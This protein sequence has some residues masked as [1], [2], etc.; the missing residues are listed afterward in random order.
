MEVCRRDT[1]VGRSQKELGMRALF[2]LTVGFLFVMA[3]TLGASA[4]TPFKIRAGWVSAPNIILP[5]IFEKKDIL[6]HYGRSYVFEAVRFT[7]AALEA[8]ALSSG[9]LEIASLGYP[10]LSTA[11]LNA[12]MEDLRV[13]ADGIQDGVN[14]YYSTEY[15]V[16]KDGPIK[17]VADL[18][19]KIVS[20]F[21]SGSA[22]DMPMRSMLRKNKLEENKDYTN[23]SVGFAN[24][25]PMLDGR[26]IDLASTTAPW[27]LDPK[28]RAKSRTLFTSLE[29]VGPTELIVLI[30]RSGTIEKNRAAFVDFFED[31]LIGL[32]WFTNPKNKAEAIAIVARFMKQP[33][34]ALDYVF[35]KTD[36]YRDPKALPNAEMLQR[37]IDIQRDLGFVSERVEISKYIDDSIVKEASNRFS[38]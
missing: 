17:T 29:A 32:R 16:L 13:I 19:G 14:G 10:A 26:K 30:S 2:K 7:S 21:V 5:F 24:M 15:M 37:G 8:T 23:I 36:F 38:N 4:Q 33:P 20:G 22:V 28:N 9:D 18:K 25:Q 11:V 1:G 3:S 35:S 34:E 6:K 31:Y 12:G 27:G